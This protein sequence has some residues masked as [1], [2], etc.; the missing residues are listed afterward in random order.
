MGKIMIQ[1][2]APDAPTLDTA[3][4]V[5][6]WCP[7]AATEPL[8]GTETILFVED[9]EFVREVTGEVLRS[10]G[11]RVLPAK[12]AV[13]AAST[14][15]L[16]GGD[17]DLLLTDVVL[18]GESGRALAG[19]LRRASPELKVLL[20]TG[21][22]EQMGEPESG[23]GACLAKPFSVGALLQKVRQVLDCSGVLDRKRTSC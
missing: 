7:G 3:E 11:Y 10:A 21:Y 15:D 20:V 23:I 12:D 4:Q 19:R 14:Y 13:A 16:Q 8:A 9:E 18:P 6:T 17:V 2:A 5:V 1:Q 22:A